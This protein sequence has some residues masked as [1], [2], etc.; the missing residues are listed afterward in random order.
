MMKTKTYNIYFAALVSLTLLV[1]CSAGGGGGTVPPS[2]P[3]TGMVLGVVVS[4]LDGLP[5]SGATVSVGT[6][7]ATTGA[8]GTYVI[9]GVPTTSRAVVNITA[10]NFAPGSKVTAVFDGSISRAD[11][12]LLPV[13]YT[14]TIASLA[15]VQTVAVPNSS[16]TV[17]LPANALV[18]GVGAAPSGNITVSVTPLDPSSN[19]QIMPGDYATNDGGQIQS[20]GALNVNMTDATG[21][22]L[23]LAPGVTSTIRIPVAAGTAP[24]ATM[25]MWYYDSITGRWVNQGT[26]ALGGIA[27]N[28]YYEG[29]VTHFSTWNADQRISTTCVT[30]KVVDVNGAPVGNARVESEGQ[31]YAGTSTA[32][33][34]ADGSF[35]IK[36]KAAAS[37]ILTARTDTALSNSEVVLGGAAG[38]TCTPMLT[39]LTLGS[40]TSGSAKIKLTWGANPSDLDSHLTG[41]TAGSATRFHVYYADQGSQVAAPYVG[42]DVD[43]ISG[44][45]PEVITINRFIPGLYR[46]SVHHFEGSSTIPASPARVE[47]TLNGVTRIFTP[48]APVVTLA[49][50]SVWVVM[51][52]TVDSTGNV[53][54]TP[55]NTYSTTPTTSG[56]SVALAKVNVT[57]TSGKPPLVGGNW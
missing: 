39:D 31:G 5:V 49:P 6:S 38:T 42:L 33:S 19:P 4:N 41:P 56:F 3:T 50:D 47:L 26:L 29:S 35:T 45:G 53:T 15:T 16:A 46:Y 7:T 54:V 23:N 24:L 43:N 12:A 21:A 25:D 13:A 9:S 11:A 2:T 27:P 14:A 32:Y 17:V 20:Y 18:T 28:Q 55:I 30:G 37:A 22:P 1:G 48:P 8:D 44:F 57:P 36:I 10:N 34:A 51:E 40:T 52:L